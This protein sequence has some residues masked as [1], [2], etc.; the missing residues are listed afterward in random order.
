MILD[1]RSEE[2]SDE[3]NIVSGATNVRL[4]LGDLTKE[5]DEESVET[6]RIDKVSAQE[7]DRDGVLEHALCEDLSAVKHKWPDNITRDKIQELHRCPD[8]FEKS[9]VENCLYI[10]KDCLNPEIYDTILKLCA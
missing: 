8:V 9:D 5:E 3:E 7:I 6:A 1:Q 4:L 2:D 10:T